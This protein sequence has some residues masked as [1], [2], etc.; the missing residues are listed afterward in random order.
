MDLS[1]VK[2]KA[3]RGNR[4]PVV[5]IDPHDLVAQIGSE[6]A[7]LLSSALER[8]TALATT[9]KIDRDSL[10]A[11]RDEVDLARRIGITGQQVSRFASG[12]V[13]VANERLNLTNLWREALRQRG[14]EIEARGI[15]VRQVF[16]PAEVSSDATLLFSLMQTVLDWSF[17][18]ALSRIDLA[19]DVRSWPAHARMVCSFAFQPADQV[20]SGFT[21]L[22]SE[23]K[24]TLE[25]MSW[26]LLQQTAAILGLVL[27]R[28]DDRGRTTLTLEFPDTLPPRV[29]TP[30]LALES[31]QEDPA[32]SGNSQPLA[33]RHVL[34]VANRR[35]VRNTVREAVRHMGMMVDFVTSVDEMVEFCRASAPHAVVYESPLRSQR[36]ERLR[37]E[38]LAEVPNLAFIEITEQGR[39]FELFNVGGRQFASVGRD[40]IVQQLPSALTFEISRLGGLAG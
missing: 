23:R 40:A 37:S 4:S 1:D 5:T 13:V 16:A 8:V 31:D 17:E 9:G 18:H 33:G 21:V 20:E 12:R 25:T 32:L 35:E 38:L 24:Q 11:L 28:K 34:V 6:V 3:A 2:D 22:D 10:R 39:A 7:S 29:E 26:R 27:Q 15:E 14:R 30:T 19:L 36:F